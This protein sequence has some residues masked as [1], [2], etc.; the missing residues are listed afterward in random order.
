M[1]AHGEEDGGIVGKDVVGTPDQHKGDGKID[2]RSHGEDVGFAGSWVSV[3]VCDVDML[4]VQ[5]I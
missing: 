3:D 4:W 2:E 5:C 1:P